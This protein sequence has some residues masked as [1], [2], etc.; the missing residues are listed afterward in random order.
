MR[1][2]RNPD[3]DLRK[4][5]KEYIE[6]AEENKTKHTVRERRRALKQHFP[7]VHTKYDIQQVGDISPD[8]VEEYVKI[9]EKEEVSGNTIK[10]EVNYIVGLCRRYNHRTFLNLFDYGELEIE[11][12]T[13][14]EQ[15]TEEKGISLEEYKQVLKEADSLR[16][17]LVCRI[18]WETGCRRSEVSQIDIQDINHD[19]IQ[20]KTSKK[21]NSYRT[22]FLSLQTAELVRKYIEFERKSYA[23]HTDT[24]ALLVTERG[25]M[26][27]HT[28]NNIFVRLCENAG[29]QQSLGENAKGDNMNLY[30]YHSLRHSYAVQRLN[31]G[32]SIKHIAEIMGD[33]VQSVSETYLQVSKQ[34]LKNA[35]QEYRPQHY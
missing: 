19:E 15:S 7:K 22:V 6:E 20:I 10:S 25:R 11:T 12:T 32:M 33:T 26:H 8:L 3:T 17:E 18:G 1:Q 21:D 23:G 27:P 29:I 5:I 31:A 30:T 4:A 2:L 24:D 13:I 34:D 16:N 35:E 9:R 28:I 14:V